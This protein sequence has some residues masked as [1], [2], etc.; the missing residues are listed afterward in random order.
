M[1]KTIAVAESCTGG[2]LGAL[3]TKTPGASEYF[4]G[5]VITYHDRVKRSLLDVPKKALVE[6][7]AVS[8]ETAKSMARGIRRK[9]R[10]DIGVSITGIA[11][12]DGGT[13]K[14]PVGLVYIALAEGKKV[15]CKRFLFSGDRNSIRTQAAETALAWIR[16]ERLFKR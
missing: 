11:G 12:P 8:E 15:R 4:L 6:N 2:L 5:G 1:R 13:K 14:K 3:L 7:G 10:A 9:T 16:R